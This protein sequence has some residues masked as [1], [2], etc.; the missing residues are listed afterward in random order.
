MIP[1]ARLTLDELARR[2]GRPPEALIEEALPDLPTKTHALLRRADVHTLADLLKLGETGLAD[3]H[4]FGPRSLALVK[5]ALLRSGPSVVFPED[6]IVV[7]RG[8]LDKE[9]L[10]TRPGPDRYTLDVRHHRP[11]DVQVGPT[12]LTAHARARGSR[13]RPRRCPAANPGSRSRPCTRTKP[14]PRSA[15][16]R[17]T[18]T[19]A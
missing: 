18:R 5:A 16:R 10:F 9:E 19:S 14:S 1:D 6:A 7:L 13:S 15:P 8:L 4:G 17:C 11:G 12:T 2:S 3:L